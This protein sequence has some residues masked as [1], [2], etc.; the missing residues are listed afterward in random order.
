MFALSTPTRLPISVMSLHVRVVKRGT[1]CMCM[2]VC[3][4][5]CVCICVSVA[6]KVMGASWPCGVCVCQ[7]KYL[8]RQPVKVFV[9]M[10]NL[11]QYISSICNALAKYN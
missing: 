5:V 6:D 10:D 3:V 11:D 7:Q 9:C 8:E 4:Y 2:Y 1:V